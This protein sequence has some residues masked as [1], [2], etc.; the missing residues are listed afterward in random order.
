MMG[1][2]FFKNLMAYSIKNDLRESNHEVSFTGI[3][4][5]MTLIA[6]CSA[7]GVCSTSLFPPITTF[8]IVYFVD[9]VSLRF[10]HR[11]CYELPKGIFISLQNKCN[12][13]QS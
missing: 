2:T 13:S 1:L 6:S 12:H 11:Q 8:L 5:N 3:H 10:S 9:I 7:F 4:E